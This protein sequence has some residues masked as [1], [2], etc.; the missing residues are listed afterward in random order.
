MESK[1]GMTVMQYHAIVEF[2]SSW[3]IQRIEYLR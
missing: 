2:E 3:Q 1:H